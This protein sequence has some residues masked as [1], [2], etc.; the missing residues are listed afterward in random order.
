MNVRKVKITSYRKIP[1]I[2]FSESV[3]TESGSKENSCGIIDERETLLLVRGFPYKATCFSRIRR[4][5]VDLIILK[6][7]YHKLIHDTLEVPD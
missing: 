2:G 5:H 6:D 1:L 7:I 3:Q 4:K